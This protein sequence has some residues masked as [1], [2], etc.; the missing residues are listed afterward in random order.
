MRTNSRF[1]F[2][3]V[4]CLSWFLLTGDALAQKPNWQLVWADEFNGPTISRTNWVYDV[5]GNGWG[6]NERQFYTDRPTNS[7]IATEPGSGKS[8]LVLQALDEKYQNRHYTSARMKTQGLHAWTYGRIEASMKVPNGQGIWPAFWM[9][10]ADF[11]KVTWPACGEID[12]MEHVLPIGPNTVRGSAH[13]P[14]YSGNNSMHCDATPKDLSGQFHLFAIEWTPTEL[15]YYVDD[16]KY[17]TV[18]PKGSSCDGSQKPLPGP[19][20]F[21]RP[22]FVI[23]NLAIGGNWPG[24]PDLKTAFPAQLWVDYVR[25]YH[26]ANQK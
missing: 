8:C 9:L 11:P 12:I 15:R 1:F 24:P 22:F 2:S 19:W 18:T 3:C 20:V 16:T 4:S 23:F 26:D 7:F 14:K 17:L 5:G 13:A 6:N 10:G 25:V 21:D